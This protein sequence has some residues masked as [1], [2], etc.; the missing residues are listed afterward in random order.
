MNEVFIID[1]QV[2][3]ISS[4]YQAIERTGNK[5]IKIC[6]PSEL[7]TEK[8]QFIILPG[9]G[10]TSHYMKE[11]KLRKFD[12]FLD[13]CLKYSNVKLLGICVGMQIL[14][15]ESEEHFSTKCLKYFQGKVKKI[16]IKEKNIQK[17]PH[18]GWNSITFKNDIIKKDKIFSEFDKSYFYFTHSFAVRA[19]SDHEIAVTEHGKSFTSICNRNNIYGIQFHPEKSGDNGQ[20]LLKKFLT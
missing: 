14:F 20:A 4:L 10:S 2:G 1:L 3:N 12:I 9:V 16:S 17:I 7:S 11:M 5:P 18:V 6:N 15:E 19:K 8:K 13:D